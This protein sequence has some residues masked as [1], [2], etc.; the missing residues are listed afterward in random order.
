MRKPWPAGEEIQSLQGGIHLQMGEKD[1]RDSV[2][3]RYHQRISVNLYFL[4]AHNLSAI[5]SSQSVTLR[6]FGDLTCSYRRTRMPTL[7][8]SIAHDLVIMRAV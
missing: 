1:K 8:V 4:E 6:F 7:K 2:Q 5:S 3:S